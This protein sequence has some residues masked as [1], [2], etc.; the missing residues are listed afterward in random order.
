MYS[1]LPFSQT[2]FQSALAH[3][4]ALPDRASLATLVEREPLVMSDEFLAAAQ[5]AATD[6]RQRRCGNDWSG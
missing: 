2:A 6:L 4:L 3:L 1:D 5:Q